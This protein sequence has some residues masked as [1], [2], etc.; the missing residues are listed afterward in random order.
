MG[1]EKLESFDDGGLPVDE[2][3][4]DVKREELEGQERF[5]G[6]GRRGHGE[7]INGGGCHDRDL[8]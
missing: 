5:S 4:V 8:G 1:E 2:R 3:A 6:D 7:G